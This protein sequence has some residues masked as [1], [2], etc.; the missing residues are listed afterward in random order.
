MVYKKGE[1][2]YKI[3]VSTKLKRNVL[4]AVV[5]GAAAERNVSTRPRI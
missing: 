4:F 5:F 2:T 3:T 1:D